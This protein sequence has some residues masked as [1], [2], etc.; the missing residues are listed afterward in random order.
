MSEL[1]T[2]YSVLK[3]HLRGSSDQTRYLYLKPHTGSD[4]LPK[5]RAIFV[6]GLPAQLGESSLLALF[7]RFGAVERVAVHPSR[8]GAVVLY[9]EAAGS[10]QAIKSARAGKAVRVDVTEPQTP[11]GLKCWVEAHKALKPGNAELLSELDEWMEAFD[12]EE[13]RRKAE[14]LAAMADEGW[15]V[16]QRHKGRKKN[17]S[18]TGVTV[19]GVAGAA[20][21]AAAKAKQPEVHRDFYRFQQRQTR[22]TELLDLRQKFEEDKQRISQLKAARRFKPY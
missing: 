8:S 7:S 2:S 17:I 11:F 21:Q 20:A 13:E 18:A 15:T 9:E 22:R 19:A 14:A 16:V 6:A 5:D 3:L 12:Q 1:S 4:A 10:S